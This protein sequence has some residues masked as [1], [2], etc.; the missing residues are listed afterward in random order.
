MISLLNA[1]WR[2]LK[3]T[4]VKVTCLMPGAISTGFASTGGSVKKR[5]GLFVY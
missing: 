2:E 3:D 5:Y 1:L 4:G